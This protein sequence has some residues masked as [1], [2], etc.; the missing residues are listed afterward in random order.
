MRTPGYRTLT[1]TTLF[2]M[3]LE[4]GRFCDCENSGTL[5]QR[6]QGFEFPWERQLNQVDIWISCPKNLS[7]RDAN[8]EQSRLSANKIGKFGFASASVRIL[9]A[10]QSR[11]EDRRPLSA[12]I[13]VIATAGQR[14]NSSFGD[15][16]PRLRKSCGSKSTKMYD[17]NVRT[18]RRCSILGSHSTTPTRLD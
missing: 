18:S 15:A 8:A 1:P 17:Q 2:P 16:R 4:S 3:I 14:V 7:A 6:G 12:Q 5:S 13:A 10:R 9:G 11:G